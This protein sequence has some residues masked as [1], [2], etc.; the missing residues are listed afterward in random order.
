VASTKLEKPVFGFK[1]AS[2]I[3]LVA[4]FP[5]V[6][7]PLSRDLADLTQIFARCKGQALAQARPAASGD[8]C[9]KSS[10]RSV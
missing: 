7:D 3:F 9:A 2:E 1:R 10:D 5:V 6:K 8:F 4:V